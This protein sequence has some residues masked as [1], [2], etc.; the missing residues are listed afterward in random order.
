MSETLFPQPVEPER[1]ITVAA[2]NRLARTAIERELPLMWVAGEISNFTQAASGHWYFALKDEAA[3][4]RCVMFRGRSLYTDFR[5]ANGMHVEAR[6]LPTLYEAR[7]EFQLSIEFLRPAGLGALHVAFERLKATLQ[8]EGLLAAARKRPIPFHPRSIGIVTSPAAA[9]LRDV[10]STLARRMPNIPVVIYPAPVQGADAGKRIAEALATAGQRKECDVLVLCR[11]GGSL[12]DLWTFN[13]EIVARAIVACPIPVVVGVGHETDFTI[14]DFAAD[15]RAPTPTAAAEL[16][17]PDRAMLNRQLE[18]MR[19]NLRSAMRR[20]L[21]NRIQRLD[22]LSRRVIHPDRRLEALR[23]GLNQSLVRMRAAMNARMKGTGMR[24]HMLRRDL[25]AAAPDLDAISAS[26]PNA[27]RRLAS[28]WQHFD[29]RCQAA[30][31]RLDM[32]LLHLN[33]HG[34]LQRGY[35][36]VHAAS[37]EIVRDAV[38]V[39]AGDV[40]TMTF[41]RGE[42]KAR[43]IGNG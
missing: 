6:A 25:R 23:I 27:A 11:G 12:E 24:L 2:L 43:V 33:P 1:I 15:L 18:D 41:A 21:E 4:V 19:R 7:G 8:A 30:V 36:I 3:Q 22:W 26:L 14:A 13:Q 9:A 37:G 40:V 35:A 29:T 10:L 34:V 38:Q 32:C 20:V 16:V 17:S 31:T 42:A 39:G 5:P 28:A